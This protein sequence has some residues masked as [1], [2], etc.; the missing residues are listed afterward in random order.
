MHRAAARTRHE[1]IEMKL[2]QNARVMTKL[3]LAVGLT[4]AIVPG[5]R[6]GRGL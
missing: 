2:L 4:S 1:G 5:I 6:I 3:L